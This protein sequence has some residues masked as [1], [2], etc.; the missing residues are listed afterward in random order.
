MPSISNYSWNA[1]KLILVATHKLALKRT[2]PVVSAAFN[3]SLQPGGDLPPD[4][5]HPDL[6]QQP[7]QN[8]IAGG[9]LSPKREANHPSN[10]DV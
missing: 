6:G 1:K 10:F 2:Q 3:N 5:A 7:G 4:F 8:G 9:K